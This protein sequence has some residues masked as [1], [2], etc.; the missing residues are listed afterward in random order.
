MCSLCCPPDPTL[1][2]EED[3]IGFVCPPHVAAPAVALDV[4]T[5]HHAASPLLPLLLTHMLPLALSSFLAMALPLR[6]PLALALY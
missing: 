1:T 5:Q 4:V 2:T 3:A 6:E